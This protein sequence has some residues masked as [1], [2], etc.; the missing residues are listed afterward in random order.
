M[1]SESGSRM[2]GGAD[3]RPTTAEHP[4]QHD[5]LAGSS[6][7]RGGRLP[8]DGA[9]GPL[10]ARSIDTIRT[11]A[12][13]AVQ[14][15]QSGHP[16]TPMGLA[17]L[18]YALWTHGMRYASA[19]PTWPDR[20]RFVLSCGHASMLQYA[21]L[22]LTGYP[23]TLDDIR[24]FRQ[25]G[26]PA[27]GH[28]ERGETPGVETTTG[29]LG[30][31]FGNAVGMALAE[32]HLAARFNTG[33]HVLVDHRTWVIASDGDLMEGVASEAASLAGHLG[34]GRLCVFW[35]DN[36]ITID[37]STDLSFSEDVGARFRSYGW[38]VLQVGDDEGVPGYLRA[39][40]GALA[41]DD[42]P[43]LVVCRTH[44]GAG[45]PGK[46][47]T[48]AAHGAPL[49]VDEVARTKQALGWPAEAH[50]L[51]PDDVAAH[52]AA[53]G[54][55]GQADRDAW[56]AAREAARAAD[57]AHVA[58]FEAALAGGAVDASVHA[59]LD[60]LAASD[61]TRT[62][63]TRKASGRALAAL[64]PVLP[65]LLGGSCDLAGSNQTRLPDTGDIQRGRHEG[66]NLHF[67]VRE[68]AMGAI[69]NGLAQHGGVRPYGGTFLVFADYMRPAIRLAA[70]MGLPVTY[71]FTH[72][73][74]GVGEDGPTHQ[75]VE[76]LASL[77]AIPNLHVIRP[78]DA[79]ETIEAWRAA[80]GRRDG[81]TALVL[82]RQDV[83]PVDRSRG[84]PVTQLARGAYVVREGA[85]APDVVLLASGS[86]LGLA[87][88]AADLLLGEG[89]T[90]RVV[91][92]PCWERIEATTFADAVGS[93]P[94][95]V[96][97][98][99]GTSFGWHRWIGPDGGLVTMDRFGASGPGE[100]LFEHFGFTPER[101]AQ[102][103]RQALAAH[104][105]R[106]D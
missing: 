11:L 54:R 45:S 55:R 91:S 58:A 62:M 33:E 46:Q 30:Q 86:E 102:A 18:A 9:A 44:I 1:S 47:D 53:A 98:E 89:V 74:I 94:V 96:A 75:P 72:D 106:P 57:P 85:Q 21:M 87:M 70:L 14:A 61:A 19:D 2:G 101:V 12:M 51:V 79:L 24:R 50:F 35:D 104:E 52:M 68:H 38:N 37:G 32:R 26:S 80:L 93:C 63:A 39:I 90:A 81:P 65:T 7:R 95:R 28:P 84:R 78:G 31:G 99:A 66:R 69:L 64:A 71:V 56:V 5:E 59:A 77:R 22:H 88:A 34:L 36:R 92:M 76:H 13:D 15:A 29:P 41:E 100:A 16:G 83:A 82:T 73:S 97:V 8:G 17:P 25:L 20:D 27:A 3:P 23:L 48:A 6:A 42:R 60:A 40:D 49:G 4:V 103:A 10:A 67:G 105:A 43:T